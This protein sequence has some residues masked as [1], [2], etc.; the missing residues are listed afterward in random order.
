MWRERKVVEM[1]GA[2]ILYH[3]SQCKKCRLLVN[4]TIFIV[5]QKHSSVSTGT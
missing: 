1:A 2:R 4:V 5:G 3:T